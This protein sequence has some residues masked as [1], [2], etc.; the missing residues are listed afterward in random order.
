MGGDIE[1]S[2]DYCGYLNLSASSGRQILEGRDAIQDF[3]SF[4]WILGHLKV[5]IW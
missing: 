2:N 1:V 3:D 4:I 5:Y